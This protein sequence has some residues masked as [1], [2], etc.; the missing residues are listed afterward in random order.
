MSTSKILI[1]IVI[2]VVIVFTGSR[3]LSMFNKSASPSPSVT[4]TDSGS[5]SPS[6]S[7]SPSPTASTKT[8]KGSPNPTPTNSDYDKL[9]LSLGTKPAT[10][11][12]KGGVD[13]IGHNLMNN[14]DSMFSYTGIDHEARLIT[15]TVVPN[16]ALEI[17]PNLFNKM[18]LPNGKSLLTIALPDAPK[19]RHYDLYA[20]VNYGRFIDGTIKLMDAQCSGK[21]SVDLTY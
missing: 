6:D 15:W 9:L 19:A 17:G 5:P 3:F 1:S 12:L 2:L 8:T 7:T 16:D 11:T 21:I 4:M 10:C 18:P 20:K 13:F 14:K